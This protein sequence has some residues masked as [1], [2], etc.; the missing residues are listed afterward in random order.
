M[1]EGIPWAH[2]DI[3]LAFNEEAPYG[4]TPK[5]GTGFGTATLVNFIQSYAK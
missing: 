5:E 4:F 3:V 1:G 2:L